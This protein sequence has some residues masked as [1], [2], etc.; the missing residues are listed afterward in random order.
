M[1]KLVALECTSCAAQIEIDEDAKTYTCEYCKTV[2]ERS[3]AAGMGPTPDTL[4]IM[5]ERALDREDFDKAMEFI[6]RGLLI[7][8]HHERLLELENQA[9]E[10]LDELDAE[11]EASQCYS[12]AQIV[13]DDVLGFRKGGHVGELLG[14]LPARVGYALQHIDRALELFPAARIYLNTKALLLWEGE[15]RLEEAI[16]CLERAVAQEDCE[17]IIK[18]NLEAM[19]QSRRDGGSWAGKNSSSCFIATAAFGTPFAAEIDVLRA[20]RDQRLAHTSSGQCFIAAYYRLSPPVARYIAD[21]PV[22]KRA[23]RALLMPLIKRLERTY[24]KK[25]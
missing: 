7:D 20:W 13:L 16:A 19:R 24:G 11:E 22:L 2:H 25:P 17:Q 4:C 6:E 3:Y 15:G 14:T 18:D 9:R 5:A 1:T 21:R 8:P 12:N 10:A 23:T